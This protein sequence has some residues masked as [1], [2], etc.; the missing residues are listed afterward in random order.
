ME[1]GELKLALEGVARFQSFIKH[2]F[3]LQLLRN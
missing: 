1:K 3:S 2:H